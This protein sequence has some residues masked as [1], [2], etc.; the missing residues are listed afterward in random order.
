MRLDHKGS[1][2][3][4]M[5]FTYFDAIPP[6]AFLAVSL[7]KQGGKYC[8]FVAFQEDI[9]LFKGKNYILLSKVN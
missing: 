9:Y 6:D 2:I 5:K 4:S 7:V 8:C 1:M 3:G